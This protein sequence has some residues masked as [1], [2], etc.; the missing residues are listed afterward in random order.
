MSNQ[1]ITS[2]NNNGYEVAKHPKNNAWYVIGYMGR[3]KNGRKQYAPVS[4][5]LK[6]KSDAMKL[7][8]KYTLAERASKLECSV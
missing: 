5:S 6:T 8:A 3:A 2:K 1:T 4:G 7:A